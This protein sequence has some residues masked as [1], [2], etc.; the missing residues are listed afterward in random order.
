MKGKV[1]ITGGAGFI[2]SHLGERLFHKGYQVV[3]L[4]KLS[5]QIHGDK[6]DFPSTL[7]EISECNVGDVADPNTYLQLPK[8]FDFV[9]HLA[10]ETGTGQSMY[11]IS[12]Y[13]EVNVLGTALLIEHL[14]KQE[15]KVKKI[16]LSSSRAVYGEGAYRCDTHGLV[17]PQERKEVDLVQGKFEPFCPFCDQEL[18]LVHTGEDAMF[19]PLSVYGITKLSQELLLMQSTKSL[20][21]PFVALRFQ[22]VYGLGQSLSNP[23]TGILS[24]FSTRMRHGQDIDIFE[25]GKESRDFVYIDDVVDSLVLALEK[26]AANGEVFNIGSGKGTSVMEVSQSLKE[27]LKAHVNLNITGKYRVG[28][29]RHNVA[30]ISKAQSLLGFIPKVNLEEG[31]SQFVEWFMKQPLAEDKSEKALSELKERGLFK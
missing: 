27:K 3:V 15:K 29:I 9:F 31:L 6:A 4:D 25:D 8:D 21:I 23:Y 30:D 26:E 18:A 24:I 14:A 10:A 19:R 22:N 11:A 17:F 16:I 7:K 13:S 20:G 12:H 1:L 5:S 2:G 28:D